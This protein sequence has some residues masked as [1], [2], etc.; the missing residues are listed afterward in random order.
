MRAWDSM[1]LEQRSL[2]GNSELVRDL[3]V[4]CFSRVAREDREKRLEFQWVIASELLRWRRSR[5]VVD[6]SDD[7]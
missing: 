1:S 7:L 3:L 5:K 2:E 6:S 4:S